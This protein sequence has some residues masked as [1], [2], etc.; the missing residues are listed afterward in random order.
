MGDLGPLPTTRAARNKTHTN[1]PVEGQGGS[2][3]YAQ[4]KLTE[5]RGA[6]R[7]R[8]EHVLAVGGSVARGPISFGPR[9][10]LVRWSQ[11]R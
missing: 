10:G 7:R 2:S 4:K 1:T 8:G 3:R 6:R 11:E 5:E 9:H